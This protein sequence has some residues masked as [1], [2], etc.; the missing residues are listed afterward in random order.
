MAIGAVSGA[1]CATHPDVVAAG[2]CDR[3]GNFYCRGGA[4]GVEGSRSFCI[5]CASGAAYVAWEDRERHGRLRA[6]FLTFK[7]SVLAP[8]EF[9]REI[10][11]EGGFGAPTGYAAIASFVGMGF[12]WLMVGTVMTVMFAVLQDSPGAPREE[13][14]LWVFPLAAIGYWASGFASSILFLFFFL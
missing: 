3:C 10:P 12:V 13:I 4:G 5:G 8:Q 9:A 2:V 7:R 1:R 14:P 11:S 6:F